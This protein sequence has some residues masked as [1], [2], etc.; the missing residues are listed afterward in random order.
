M[1]IDNITQS[2][3]K[4]E[5]KLAA[6]SAKA[7]GEAATI[8]K[9]SA[10]TKTALDAIGTREMLLPLIAEALKQLPELTQRVRLHRAGRPVHQARQPGRVSALQVSGGV[11]ARA[12]HLLRQICGGSGLVVPQCVERA[13]GGGLL[14]GWTGGSGGLVV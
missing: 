1:T 14:G 13:H 11:Q 6:M 10:D 12:A 8:G 9:I 2:L 3:D 5:S 7:D 4:I